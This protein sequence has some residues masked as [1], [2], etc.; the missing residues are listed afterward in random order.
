[1]SE[2]EAN[3]PA[4]NPQGGP[5]DAHVEPQD[6][7]SAIFAEAFGEPEASGTPADAGSPPAPADPSNAAP[8]QN[9]QGGPASGGDE[10]IPEELRKAGQRADS[11]A[12]RLRKEREELE[13]KRQDYEKIMAELQAT[14]E[15]SR[16]LDEDLAQVRQNRAVQPASKA[17]P[18]EPAA[19]LPMVEIPDELKDEARDFEREYPDLAHLLRYPGKEGETLRKLLAEYG[20]DVAATH[21]NTVMAMYRLTQAEADVRQKIEQ[22][23]QHTQQQQ[24]EMQTRLEN[25]R[26]QAHYTQI[27]EAVPEYGAIAEDPSRRAELEQFHAA[28]SDWVDSRPYRE[29]SRMLEILRQGDAPAVINVLKAF[30]AEQS[31]GRT[32]AP[33]AARRAAA[34]AAAAVPSRV[35]RPPTRGRPDPNDAHAAYREAFGPV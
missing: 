18:A 31:T 19:S 32:E 17:A 28:L 13:R 25:E 27:Y 12:G 6:D 7:L 21:G 14:Q 8:A 2:H 9:P 4:Q 29:A 20:P 30:Q 35:P 16:K 23:G 24:Q 33:N 5:A 11:M 3:A 22:L 26:R 15:E 34:Q 10:E 1:M